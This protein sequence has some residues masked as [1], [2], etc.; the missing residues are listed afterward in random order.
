MKTAHLVKRDLFVDDRGHFTNIPLLLPELKFK[1]KRVYVCDNFQTGTVRGYHHHKHEAKIFI[2]LKGGIKFVLL[3]GDMMLTD[4]PT[5]WK[6]EVFTLSGNLPWALY[7][8]EN[9]AN[10]WQ[11]LTDD[12]IMIGVSNVT[13]EASLEDDKRWDP[14]VNHSEYWET[15]SR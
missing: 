10:A 14:K 3:P 1:G 8:P 5:G 13:V 2:C 12:A 4:N 11:T 15:Q 7:V 9:Y 6:P